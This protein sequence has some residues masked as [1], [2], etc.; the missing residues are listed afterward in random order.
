MKKIIVLM[1]TVLL[2]STQSFAGEADAKRVAAEKLINLFNMEE[3]YNQ[4]MQQAMQMS[5][6]MID[7]QNISQ[8]EKEKAKNEIQKSM[9]L[10][11]QKFSWDKMKGIFVDIYADVYTVEEMEGLSQFF[12]SPIGQGFIKKQP[13]L[14]SAMMTK[15]QSLMQEIM[16]EQM[17]EADKLKNDTSSK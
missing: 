15:M 11:T 6:K 2:I 8:E 3:S 16:A 13:Q 4:T 12:E 14:T 17:K 9:N 1:F 5:I 10:T 7:S